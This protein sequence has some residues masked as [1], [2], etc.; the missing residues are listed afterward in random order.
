MK[1]FILISLLMFSCKES[2]KTYSDLIHEQGKKEEMKNILNNIS[3]LSAHGQVEYEIKFQENI[4]SLKSLG[5]EINCP[6]FTDFC[7][8]KWN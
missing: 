8:I 2:P 6:I 7:Y 1:K 4:D 5:F 3:W